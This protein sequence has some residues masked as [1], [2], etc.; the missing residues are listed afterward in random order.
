M[1]AKKRKKKKSAAP[2]YILLSFLAVAVFALVFIFTHNY[3]VMGKLFPKD[4]PIDL[5]DKTVSIRKF[6][7]ISER[8]PDSVV[9]WNV[10][11][12]EY[13][14]DCLSEEISV[15][16]FS[17]KELE[18]FSCFPYLRS[19]D[20]RGADCSEEIRALIRRYPSLDVHWLVPIGEG[21]YD[22]R[23]EELAV[24]DFSMNEL[25][26]FDDFAS[27][28]RVD[29][30][31]ASC[32][33]EILALREKLGDEIELKWNVVIGGES[34][35]YTTKELA[36]PEGVT[37]GE[38]NEK[39]SYLPDTRM[40]DTTNA[41]FE[42]SE[43][44]TL[45][46]AYPKI[47]FLFK[48]TI[49]GQSIRSNT[50]NINI[51]E[52]AALDL[53]EL[54]EHGGD[55]SELKIINLGT[56]HME[57]DDVIAIREA[58]DGVEVI[59]GVTVCGKECSTD[60]TELDLSRRTIEDLGEAEKAIKAMARLEKLYLCDC[61]IDNETLAELR[62]KYA[63][64][65]QIVWRVYLNYVDCR[66]DD[67]SFCMSKYDNS[68]GYLPYQ[69]AE[70][71]KYC[72]AM[73][74]LDLGHANFD[75]I[76]FVS[77]MPHLKYLIICSAPVTSLEPLRSATELYYLEMFFT[78]VR[79]IE[80]ITK[81]PS[82]KHLNLSHCRLDDYTQLFEMTQ[83]E[84]LW[85]VDSGLTE[86]QQNELREAL[87]DTK[88]CFWAWNDDAVGNYWRDDPS[89]REMRDNLGMNYVVIA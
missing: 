11:I 31:A 2:F 36:L 56:R 77:T 87:P 52:T 70:P 85:W 57:L 28:R 51:P 15:G 64:Q 89:Y 41:Q 21:R 1:A 79:D 82:L 63:D 61:G 25:D 7:S 14:Y 55:F 73:E 48:V 30:T 66:T 22:N 83:L 38:V 54:L 67:K 76:D 6:Q 86:A 81:L 29:A 12:G 5:R 58:Y 27:L 33:P 47:R 32:Y 80:P 13:S 60:W 78:N 3:L 53:D 24:G 84:R 34:F 37:A 35:P 44:A 26:S 74:T 8:F 75:R 39:L 23:S 18:N 69:N 62:D 17:M 20:A 65:T 4:E 10:P 19:V 9:L 71:I 42:R 88:I 49:A 68:W 43:L 72:T 50:E 59:C 40:V 16:N 46:A 45:R